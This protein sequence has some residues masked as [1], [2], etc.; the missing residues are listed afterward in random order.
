[1]T[2]KKFEIDPELMAAIQQSREF[3]NLH[4]EQK[5]KTKAPKPKPVPE[6]KP[7]VIE[8]GFKA[9]EDVF[10]I[11]GTD[12]R[13]P[14]K[15]WAREDWPTAIRDRIPE[16]D[17]NYQWNAD[18]AKR[19]AYGAHV[20]GPLL[21]HG[22]TGTGKTS[23]LQQFAALTNT[24]FFRVSCHAQME[25]S[26]FLGSNSVVQEDGA[27]VTKHTDTDTTLAA[28]YGGML[29]VDEA[30]RSPILMA[31][32]AMLEVPTSLVLQD[33]HGDSRTLTP[34]RKL[35]IALTDNTN[36][37][38]AEDGRF[39]ANI[40]DLSTLDRIRTTLYVDY[41][42]PEVERKL[43]R[44]L[45]PD[46]PKATVDNMIKV[47]NEI[48]ASFKGG[49]LMQTMSVRGLMNWADGA[50]MLGD[51]HLA[52]EMHLLDKLSDADRIV[53]ESC[54]R[55]AFGGEQPED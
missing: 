20:E 41:N 28:K 23:M 26:D 35:I 50:M 14:I 44:G 39:D 17:P 2:D 42:A 30:F 55:Q 38:G 43:L 29:C 16:V 54:Y 5:V 33:A 15:V 25:S 53:A 52:Y 19:L 8:E 6:V 11:T 46:M 49:N 45:V 12:V 22:P 32:Q 48:R 9:F 51:T 13:V 21:L 34:E 36:G 37:T 40:Q 47:A 24:P 18:A 31:I 4:K 27:S 1:M 7:L 3:D 10:G